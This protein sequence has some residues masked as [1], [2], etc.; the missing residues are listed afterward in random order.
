MKTVKRPVSEKFYA[1][2]QERVETILKSMQYSGRESVYAM[3]YIDKYLETGELPYFR[4]LEEYIRAVVH[5][6][7]P[8]IDEAIARS[9]ACRERAAKRRE[10]KLQAE[11]EK[12]EQEKSGSEKPE[13][14]KIEIEETAD[15]TVRNEPEVTRTSAKNDS[16]SEI[17]QDDNS[18]V[19]NIEHYP[20]ATNV[21]G[22]KNKRKNKKKN[23][24][25][26]RCFISTAEVSGNM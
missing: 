19:K 26:R 7:A 17:E 1:K 23:R 12:L 16:E 22:H 14:G 20:M 18:S 21:L 15:K 3:Y 5:A 13:M 8:T 2:L 6:L 24:T 10:R 25:D 11:Q 9:A 4:Q